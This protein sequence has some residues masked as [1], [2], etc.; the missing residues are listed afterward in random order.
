VRLRQTEIAW[1][2]VVVGL[3]VSGGCS[4]ATQGPLV[5]APLPPSDPEVPSVTNPMID[6]NRYPHTAADTHFMSGMIPHH[7]QAVLIARWAPTHGARAD[8]QRLCER[9]V[10]AQRDEIALMQQW[11]RDRG[12][13]VPAADA[14]HHRMTMADGM[15]HDMLMPGMLNEQELRELDRARG[16]EWDRLFLRAMI[17][18]HQGAITMV[19]ELFSTAGAAQDDIVFKFANDVYA[20]QT[21]EIDF[22][23]RMLDAL[24]QGGV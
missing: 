4:R 12:E 14:T 1:A 15:T 2:V 8:I 19:D 20:D 22:M 17:K 18:H 13:P 5:G 11:L 6:G 23:Q 9:I 3:A 21:T 7:A 16:P 10:V 24:S